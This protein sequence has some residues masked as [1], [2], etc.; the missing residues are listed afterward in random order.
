MNVKDLLKEKGPAITIKAG[1]TI[2][3][4]MKTMIDRQIGS[5]IITNDMGNPIGIITEHDIFKTADRCH[6]NMMDMKVKDNMTGTVASCI[7]TD[8]VEE[9]GRLMIQNNIRHIPVTDDGGTVCGVLSIRDILMT[10]LGE[11]TSPTK[12]QTAET[13]GTMA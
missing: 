11:K 2:Q 8:T 10:L 3:T 5:L 6:G 1:A 13:T 9:I 7:T 4:A 12:R